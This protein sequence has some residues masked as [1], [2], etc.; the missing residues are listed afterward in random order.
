VITVAALSPSLDITYLV[1]HLE[2]GMIHRPTEVHRV[3]GGKPLNLARAMAALGAAVHT[4]AIL[5]GATGRFIEQEL[6][7][8][9]ITVRPVDSPAE[10]RTCVSIAAADRDALTEIY[11]YAAA[12]PEPV[13]QVFRSALTEELAGSTGW[14]A[15]NGSAPRGLDSSVYAEL[16]IMAHDAGLKVAVDTHGPALAGALLAQPE[17]IKVNRYEAAELIGTAADGADLGELAVIISGRTGGEVIITDGRDGAVGC[18]PDGATR[19]VLL[20]ADVVGRYPVGSGDA[21]LGGWLAAIDRGADPT[22][23][24]QLATGCGAA[25]ALVPGAGTFDAATARQ[26]AERSLVSAT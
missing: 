10:T 21:F 9:D 20:P 12:V 6:T 13:W 11:E 24:L 7:T 22:A 25:N 15:I 4:V 1:E 3:A 8:A 16:V 23:A 19:R 2:L 5:G 26:I 14:L 18:S 17:L